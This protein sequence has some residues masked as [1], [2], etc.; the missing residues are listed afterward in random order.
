MHVSLPGPWYEFYMRVVTWELI[1]GDLAKRRIGCRVL[2]FTPWTWLLFRLFF[3]LSWSMPR[4]WHYKYQPSLHCI[5]TGSFWTCYGASWLP[6]PALDRFSKHPQWRKK[7]F[8]IPTTD[9]CWKLES[10]FRSMKYEV[11]NYKYPAVWW[12][13]LPSILFGS[14][15][16]ST[17][18]SQAGCPD[19]IGCDWKHLRWTM[20]LL[21]QSQGYY[22]WL[23]KGHCRSLVLARWSS[24][25]C[26]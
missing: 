9:P 15:G 22:E 24:H 14:L 18:A 12:F 7:D 16:N 10:T 8:L 13:P 2:A 21:C 3:F 19:G 25:F 23:A 5:C 11:W 26:D 17:L 4:L 20:D 1:T 6:M